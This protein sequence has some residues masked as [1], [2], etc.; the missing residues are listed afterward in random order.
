MA[1]TRTT[2]GPHG[3]PGRTDPRRMDAFGEDAGFWPGQLLD[4]HAPRLPPVG[5][6]DDV[7]GPT[8]PEVD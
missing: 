5:S 1:T 8:E 4:G 6:P 3:R 7:R 2:G